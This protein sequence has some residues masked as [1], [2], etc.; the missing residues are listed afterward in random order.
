MML[1]DDGSFGEQ[2]NFFFLS[3]LNYVFIQKL[4]YWNCGSMCFDDVINQKV[5]NQRETAER[6]QV[7]R[8]VNAIS[9]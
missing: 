1:L 2:S 6:T 9:I 7:Q 4:K 3:N 8:N 5:Y